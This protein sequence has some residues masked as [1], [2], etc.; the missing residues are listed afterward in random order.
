M[1]ETEKTEKTDKKPA[2]LD[3]QTLDKV[4]GGSR[5]AGEKQQDFP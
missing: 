1:S 5:K 4:A 2:E 3:E